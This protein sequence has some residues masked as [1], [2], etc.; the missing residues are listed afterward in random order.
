MIG[1]CYTW[2][3]GACSEGVWRVVTR[4]A[5]IPGVKVIRN[6]KVEEMVPAVHLRA[7]RIREPDPAST[8]RID[9]ELYAPS[10]RWTI[11]PWYPAPRRVE[12]AA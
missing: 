12:C 6:V 9:G 11:R 8:V 5:S 4:W 2:R 10:G 3:S 1:R 7:R